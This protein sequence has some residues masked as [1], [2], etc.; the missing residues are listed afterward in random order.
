MV[1]KLTAGRKA[2]WLSCAE[3]QGPDSA[4]GELGL[5]RDSIVDRAAVFSTLSLIV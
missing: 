2:W 3:G 1:C 5:G 4:P